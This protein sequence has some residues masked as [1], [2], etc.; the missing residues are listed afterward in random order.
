MHD[1][2][3]ELFSLTAKRMD[4]T[5]RI[6]KILTSVQEYSNITQLFNRINYYYYYYYVCILAACM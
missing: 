1:I 4:D 5:K 3:F 2:A 6:I